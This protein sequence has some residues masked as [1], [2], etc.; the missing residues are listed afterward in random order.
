M[1]VATKQEIKDQAEY[2][3]SLFEEMN[4]KIEALKGK[5]MSLSEMV[6]NISKKIEDISPGTT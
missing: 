3:D 4:M 1:T 2:A 6:S 5:L